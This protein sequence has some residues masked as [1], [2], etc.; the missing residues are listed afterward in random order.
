MID[1][2]FKLDGIL[3]SWPTSEKWNF[4]QISELTE[5]SIPHVL[6]YLGEGL[7]KELEVSGV[8]THEEAGEAIALLRRRLRPQIEERERVFAQKQQR[9]IQICDRSMQKVTFMQQRGQWHT[10]FKSLCYLVGQYEEHLP[11]KYVTSLC[12]EIVRCGLKAKE[13]FQELSHWLEKAII[14]AL[15]NQSKDGIEEALDF[16]DAYADAFMAEDSAK[17]PLLLGNILAVL[18]EPA[19]RFELWEEYKTLVGHIYPIEE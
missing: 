12:S 15:N 5:T 13:N 10:A 1:F 4:N 18:E 3:P 9:A 14:V 11:G 16:V 17:A 6:Q 19:A 8:I 7:G 2:I